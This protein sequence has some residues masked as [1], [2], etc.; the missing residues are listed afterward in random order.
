MEYEKGHFSF[1]RIVFKTIQKSSLA[2]M[3][4]IIIMMTKIV[5]EDNRD[6]RDEGYL[7]FS[8]AM[9]I[10]NCNKSGSEMKWNLRFFR[11]FARRRKELP[12]RTLGVKKLYIV[13]SIRF[14]LISLNSCWRF[15]VSFSLGHL[16]VLQTDKS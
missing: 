6:K 9:A 11:L 2:Q 12:R 8:F 1:L 13:F 3:T 16:L 15:A 10:L 5:L 7:F 4:M 14:I